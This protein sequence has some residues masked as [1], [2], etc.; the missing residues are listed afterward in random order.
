MGI[1]VDGAGY[2]YV[3]EP[4]AN[5]V[6]KF[7]SDGTFVTKWGTAGTGAGEFNNP[8]GIAV[9]SAGSVYVVD[10]YNHRIQKFAVGA[11]PAST[12]TVTATPTSTPTAMATI[13]P[14]DDTRV[15]AGADRDG[16]DPHHRRVR[17]R[18]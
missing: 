16:D 6:Q 9:D 3:T 2:V 15:H 13:S 14:A 8:R 7:T 17:R 4:Y 1:A 18:A 12:P 5:R 11:A 10:T